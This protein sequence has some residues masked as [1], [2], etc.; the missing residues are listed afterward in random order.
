MSIRIETKQV[1]N[2]SQD[3]SKIKMQL[4]VQLEVI[5]RVSRELDS[6][7]KARAGI[8][9]QLHRLKYALESKVRQLESLEK[10]L[11]AVAEDYETVENKVCKLLGE[12]QEDY[13]KALNHKAWYEGNLFKF[14]VGTAVIVGLGI[15]AFTIGGPVLIGMAVGAAI[16]AGVGGL[17]GGVTSQM[18]GGNFWDGAAD[19]WMVGSISGAIS[20]GV[21][22][23]G[24]GLLGAVT[25][26]G[27]VDSGVYTYE[28][29]KNGEQVTA[30]G[31]ATSFAVGAGFS[32]LG[33]KASG[34]ISKQV[35]AK[36]AVSQVDE[37]V[38]DVGKVV[39]ETDRLKLSMWKYAPSDEHYLKF[40]KVFD[41]PKYYDQVTGDI[42]WPINDGF[43]G[44]ASSMNLKKGT[45]IDR[46]GF[47][48]GTFVSPQGTSYEM[49]ALA[50]GTNSKPYHVY[51]VVKPIDCLGGKIVSWFDEIGGGV[52]Y[53]MSK[54][55]QELLDEGFIKEVFD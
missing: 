52:Q 37:V 53:K 50:P 9:G 40:K 34:F 22:G 24:A 42:K 1:R 55:I 29:F 35:A 27:L 48:T 43:D 38:E 47:E 16:G 18:S 28:T 54:S 2:S 15:A 25:A 21:S 51:E 36:S 6:R 12:A 17:I 46:Y 13:E 11:V 19:G 44:V 14:A 39:S 30:A 45:R 4:N 20:G 49:R 32:F 7:L 41:N 3:V 26:D 10:H 33:T 23:S 8:D 5:E 31:L